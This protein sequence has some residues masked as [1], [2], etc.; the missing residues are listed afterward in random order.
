MT[1]P[2]WWP[3]RQIPEGRDKHLVTAYLNPDPAQDRGQA[4]TRGHRACP[5]VGTRVGPPCRQHGPGDEASTW[6]H[7]HHLLMMRSWATS[8]PAKWAHMTLIATGFHDQCSHAQPLTHN[9]YSSS[10][11]FDNLKP[12]PEP[13]DDTAS[14]CF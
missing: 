1:G 6:V 3:H 5:G 11:L 14:I 12:R 13:A 7:V 2:R 10:L 9:Y 8:S 4:A